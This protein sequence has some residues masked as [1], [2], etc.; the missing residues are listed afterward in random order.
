[1]LNFSPAIS[2]SF[3]DDAAAF[4]AD[5]SMEARRKRL[6]EKQGEIDRRNGESEWLERQQKVRR[7]RGLAFNKKL[8]SKKQKL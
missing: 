3:S 2:K 6:A 7:S 8:S 5:R 1:M 4:Q